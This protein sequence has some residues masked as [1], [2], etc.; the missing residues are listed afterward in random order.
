[1]RQI[2]ETV[3]W[4]NRDAVR[5]ANGMVELIS[6][7]GGGHFA[8]FRFINLDG[9]PRQN[10]LWEAPWTTHDPDRCWS[11]EM[12][13]LYGPPETGRFLSSFTGHALC[14]DYFGDPPAERAAAGLGLHGEAAC[15]RW[16]VIDS[17][18]S[19][20]AH[21][22]LLA[23]LPLSG[24]TFE[25][26]I[27]LGNGQSVVYV[28]ETVHNKRDKE[29]Q[30]DWVQHVTFGQPFLCKS[31]SSLIASAESG[32]TSPFGY[33]GNSLLPA[34]S[35]FS[36][37]HVQRNSGCETVDL[38]LPFTERGSGFLA[39]LRLDPHHELE[40]VLA[41]N[42]KLGLGVGYLFHRRDFPWMTIW[43]ENCARQDAPWNGQTQARGMEFGTTPL[44]LAA[45]GGLSDKRFSD[46][47]R[48][49]IIAA[50]GMRTARYIMFLFAVPAEMRSADNV[51]LAGDAISICDASGTVSLS[52]PAEACEAF[53]A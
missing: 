15:T 29:H 32:M 10:V 21:C 17:A 31:D 22:R 45:N 13:R 28:Q 47:P 43:E 33:E 35:Y 12:S 19:K 37:P 3:R 46:T 16:D 1:M 24:L 7:A 44:P 53:L 36:W 39:G 6:L 14:L 25:R 4:K 38:R 34:N 5:L 30:C 49:C 52:V 26:D 23:N 42:W 48:G 2:C 9:R 11:E 40:Y 41:I 18:E 27:R 50:H 51:V 8:A 20:D